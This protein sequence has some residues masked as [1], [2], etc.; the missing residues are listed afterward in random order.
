MR[1]SVAVYRPVALYLTNLYAQCGELST[2]MALSPMTFS[3]SL[4]KTVVVLAC[5]NHSP[6]IS[7]QSI[8]KL[9]QI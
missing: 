5:A 1:D 4:R 8:C 3:K 6:E 7:W 9:Y 2:L